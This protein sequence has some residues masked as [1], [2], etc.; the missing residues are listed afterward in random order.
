MSFLSRITGLLTRGGR[1]DDRLRQALEHAKGNRP[2]QA[3]EIYNALLDSSRTSADVRAK[4]M[5]N[6][7]LA[8]SSVKDDER[9]VA[10]LTQ[11][12]TLPNLPENIQIA[13]RSQLA[14]VRKRGDR[15]T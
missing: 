8:Y 9:A 15:H 6:R 7:A 5:F 1:D 2:G 12:L 14:R 11:V 10:D 13:A 3:I 4:A